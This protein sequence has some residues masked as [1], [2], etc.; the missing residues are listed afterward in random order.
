[1][2]SLYQLV[3]N[4][5]LVPQFSDWT[6]WVF[7]KGMCRHGLKLHNGLQPVFWKGC[8]SFTYPILHVSR[9]I[10]HKLDELID[11][12]EELTQPANALFIL[13]LSTQGCAGNCHTAW[14]GC[15]AFCTIGLMRGAQTAPLWSLCCRCF[16]NPL[17]EGD[18]WGVI[19]VQLTSVSLIWVSADT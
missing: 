1:M 6:H 17:R 19:S 12:V 11:L 16:A 3:T 7:P 10:L 14:V 5:F 4:V 13:S 9:S 8:H 15:W 18:K 2:A